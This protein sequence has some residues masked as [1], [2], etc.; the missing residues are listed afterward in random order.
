MK[1]QKG[2]GKKFG[3]PDA[4]LYRA[5]CLLLGPY[6]RLR[7]GVRYD[8]RA[9]RGQK[10]PMLVLCPHLSNYDFIIVGLA[11]RRYLPNFVASEHFFHKGRLG[12][13]LHRMRVIPKKMFCPDVST[14]LNI[15]RA[16]REGNTVVLF[17]EGRLGC[18]FHSL[19]VAEGTSA[20]IRRAGVPVYVLTMSGASLTFPKWSPFKRPGKI[21]V[22]A[23]R[24]FAAGEASG[25]SVAEIDARV[26]GAIRHDEEKAM[27]GVRYRCPDTTLGL[28][29]VLYRCPLCGAEGTL[30]TRGGYIRCRCGLDATLDETYRLH[31]APFETL[32]GWFD[33]QQRQVDLDTPLRSAVTVAAADEQGVLHPDAGRGEV[34]LSR[35][36]FVYTGTL[37]GET[38]SLSLDPRKIRA[39]PVTVGKFFDAY[40]GKRLLNFYPVPD[41]RMAIRFVVWLDR[42]ME[43]TRGQ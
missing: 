39:F 2:K 37:D 12:K 11:L 25:L 16:L 26:D 7:Y 34:V 43:E 27:A 21:R 23:E 18:Y 42:L 32:N 1:E 24:L 5:A 30:E 9:L 13:L 19:P 17:P 6:Y 41:G 38:V 33:W 3:R 22:T 40:F 20:L 15:S 10:G 8:L 28:D 29:G 35:E 14:I 31:D 36:A 4:L